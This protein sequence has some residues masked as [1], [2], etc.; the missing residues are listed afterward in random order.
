MSGRSQRQSAALAQT[1]Q[2]AAKA[3]RPISLGSEVVEEDEEANAD[4]WTQQRRD[5]HHNKRLYNHDAYPGLLDT[6]SQLGSF[7][8]ATKQHRRNPLKIATI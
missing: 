7:V 3:V 8:K 4:H 2:L 6:N 1:E 5:H